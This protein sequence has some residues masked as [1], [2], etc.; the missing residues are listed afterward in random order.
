MSD[1]T[2]PRTG[3]EGRIFLV[4]VPRSGTTLLQ[5]LVAA[6]SR[7]TSFTESHL[8]SRPFRQVPG[9]GPVLAEDPTPRLREFLD[10]NQ[11]SVADVAP[12]FGPPAPPEL[13]SKIGLASHTRS[14]AR[15]LVGVLDALAR[16]RGMAVWLEKTPRH[17]HA[18][19][20][21]EAICDDGIPTRFVH[22]FRDGLQTVASLHAASRQW[23]EAYDL[24]T[25]I[26]R[27]NRDLVRSARFIG[28]AGHHFV[29]YETLT[30]S[31]EAVLRALFA[32]L[33]LSWE[34]EVL[35]GFGDAAA[36]LHT[37]DEAWK[38]GLAR[39]IEPSATAGEVLDAAQRK[40]AQVRLNPTAYGQLTKV[41]LG[42]PP[43]G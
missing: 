4:G 10:E 31:P 34:A 16:Q 3:L 1:D 43:R 6:H 5:S 19:P 40:R 15:R 30:R 42:E 7:V 13:A 21:L 33:E 24:D 11:A 22:L 17:L 32:A 25:C 41:A 38:A 14:V 37:P 28:R 27:W 2:P 29:R 39:P 12:W 8:F 23:P 35:A 18:L 26:D 36:E 9:L 20:L